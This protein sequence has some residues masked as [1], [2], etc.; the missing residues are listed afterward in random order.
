[1]PLPLAPLIAGGIAA[2][3]SVAG[4]A[5]SA[6]ENAEA[7]R[8][9]NEKNIQLQKEFA[10]QGVRWKVADAEA[11]GIHP[12]YAL[13]AQTHSFTPLQVGG[14]VSIGSGLAAAGQDI[15]R[16]IHATQTQDERED[17]FA[18]LKLEN[19]SL[20]NDL[21]RAQ[22]S[23]LNQ[24]Q[25]GPSFPGS[26]AG[27]MLD[28]QGNSRPTSGLVVDKPLE[29]TVSQPG[30]P[31]QEA[32]AVSDYGYVKTPHGYAIVPSKDVK[33]RIEDQMI[34]ETSWAVR[35]QLL[36]NFS[37]GSHMPIAK[38]PSGF[39]AWRWDYMLQQYVPAK[40]PTRADFDQL[41]EGIKKRY[42]N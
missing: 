42:G 19:A 31:Y 8:E 33:E 40:V 30:R 2:G 23:K 35:N 15:S 41:G 1:M 18:A 37:P 12:L 38:P 36:P 32:G 17:K 9:I 5:I 6:S 34:P 13:G 21:L 14:D 39:N 20:Q 29:R 7:Q 25:S 28:G 27:L 24:G 11:A 16:A 10:Q 4:A 22:I 3:G 26:G